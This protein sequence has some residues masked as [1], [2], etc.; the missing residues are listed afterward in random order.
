M[1]A[2]LRGDDRSACPKMLLFLLQTEDD[3]TFR[4]VPEL[5]DGVGKTIDM[6][7]MLHEFERLVAGMLAAGTR[8]AS[9]TL[10]HRTL[11]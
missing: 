4:E 11:I 7:A 9:A 3:S 5:M 2:S 10:K 8:S 1:K 6:A